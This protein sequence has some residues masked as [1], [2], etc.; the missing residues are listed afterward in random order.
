MPKKQYTIK[1][2]EDLFDRVVNRAEKENRS[3]NNMFEA[4]IERG[5]MFDQVDLSKI[6]R[7]KSISR[8]RLTEKLKYLDSD[9]EKSLSHGEQMYCKTM[10]RYYHFS[11]KDQKLEISIFDNL[12]LTSSINNFWTIPPGGQIELKKGACRWTIEIIHDNYLRANIVDEFNS[13]DEYIEIKYL[14]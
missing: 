11:F 10:G 1:I 13:N 2:D 14:Y 12:K 3:K 5:F 8:G 9:V 4:L 6:Q 7:I